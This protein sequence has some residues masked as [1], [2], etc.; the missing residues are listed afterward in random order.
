MVHLIHGLGG[1][2][3]HIRALLDWPTPVIHLSPQQAG[4]LP[5]RGLAVR[6]R[7]PWIRNCRALRQ[8]DPVP[9]VRP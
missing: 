3:M 6:C 9:Y 7:H 8:L 1:Q 2:P 4:A 5:T